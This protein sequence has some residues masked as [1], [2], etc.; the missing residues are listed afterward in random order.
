MKS[1]LF[2]ILAFS[3]VSS[4]TLANDAPAADTKKQEMMKAWQEYSTPGAP[5][6]ILAG[7]TGKWKYTSKMWQTAEGAPEESIGT[8][9]MKMIMGGR[10]LQH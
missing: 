4:L 3:I 8:S 6:K 10:F 2:S 1:I 5:H 7:L 9:S